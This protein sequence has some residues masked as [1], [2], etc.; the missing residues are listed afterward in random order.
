[1]NNKINSYLIFICLLLFFPVWSK[2]NVRLSGMFTD[3]M[4][5]QRDVKVLVWGWADKDEI[6]TVTFTGK[7]YTAKTGADDKWTVYLDPLP[8]GGPYE[9]NINGKNA[10]SLKNILMGDVW[11]CSGQSNMDMSVIGVKNADWE[12]EHANYPTIR[13]FTAPVKLSQRPLEDVSGGRWQE[14]NPQSV[15]NFSAAAYFFARKINTDLNIPVGMI[16]CSLGGTIIQPWMSLE[17]ISEFKDYLPAIEELKTRDYEQIIADRDRRQAEWADSLKNKE[18]GVMNKWYLPETDVTDW[19]TVDIPSFSPSVNK[20]N[21][22]NWYRKEIQLQGEEI[23]GEVVFHLGTMQ[24]SDE[25]WLNGTKIGSSSEYSQ[26]R[27][28]KVS[29]DLLRMGKNVLVVK[30]YNSWG[31]GG[32]TSKREEIYVQTSRG[33]KSL[34]GQWKYKAGLFGRQ[35]YP[36]AHP[37]SYPG[38][39]Y[40]G[41]VNPVTKFPIKGALWYQGEGNADKAEE[42]R[43]LLAAMI[44]DWRKKWG[45]G[46]FPFLIVQLP[47]YRK[48]DVQPS[49]SAWASLREAQA[50]ALALPNTGLAV[51]IDVGQA[52]NLH[53]VN[54]QDVGYRLA[55]QAL[56]VAYGKKDIVCSGPVFSSQTV[57]GSKIRLKFDH[58]GT[59]LVTRNQNGT[60]NGF[61]ICGA[62][63]KFVWAKARIEN[64]NVIVSSE[65]VSNPVA[66]RYAW[67]DNPGE[68]DLYNKEGLPARPFRTRCPKRQLMNRNN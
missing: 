57:E 26:T 34:S 66:V 40:N 11:I 4:V 56:K 58:I 23:S 16:K 30:I 63:G 20:K 27:K 41:M 19:K 48:P 1:M 37:N 65:E 42:Y 45:I 29:P 9:M 12:I 49:E 68:I 52:D 33:Q 54:K 7:R 17:A 21:G 14:C 15:A 32:F 8:A 60:I 62:D 61:A 67:S 10:I 5:L 35:S 44:K 53:P 31:T 6:V 43:D 28:Y 38:L 47:N 39:L 2:A 36:L 22:N 3:D 59:G 24:V 50:S 46:D 51:T 55:L 13:L 25:A 18:P 64:D